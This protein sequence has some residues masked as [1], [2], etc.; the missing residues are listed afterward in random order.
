MR[1]SVKNLFFALLMMFTLTA[2]AWAGT[3]LSGLMGGD[4]TDPE[5]KIQVPST[6]TTA[7]DWPTHYTDATW[8]SIQ[9]YGKGP[10]QTNECPANLFNNLVG[11]GTYKWFDSFGPSATNPA[12]VT[13]QFPEAFVL[14][15]FTLTSGNDSMTSRNP[16]DWCIYGSND[17]VNWTPIYHATSTADFTETTN[18][19]L[20]YSSFTY[21]D[22]NITSDT[23][24]NDAQKAAVSTSLGSGKTVS[25]PDFATPAAYSWY[26]LQV[27]STSGGGATQLGELELF[28][29]KVSTGRTSGNPFLPLTQLMDHVGSVY[30]LDAQKSSSLTVDANNK[31]SAWRDSNS[32]GF[33]F[34]QTTEEF[35]PVLST[36]TINGQEFNALEFTKTARDD[37]H[38]QGGQSLITNQ[39]VNAQTVFI[40]AQN[41]INDSLTGIWGESYD[42]GIRLSSGTGLWQ[43]SPGN[44][45]DFI[46]AQSGTPNGQ[47]YYNGLEK[48]EFTGVL[49]NNLVLTEAAR[50][51][52]RALNTHRIGSYFMWNDYGPGSR[53]YD[54]KILEVVVYDHSLTD[55]ETKAVNTSFA[56]K[57]GIEIA[58]TLDIFPGPINETAYKND[59]IGVINRTIDGKEYFQ[60]CSGEG[61]LGIYGKITGTKAA[62]SAYD[63]FSLTTYQ[64]PSDGTEIYAVA[65]MPAGTAAGILTD[66]EGIK[67]STYDKWEKEWYFTNKSVGAQDW[68]ITL[69][70][71]AEEANFTDFE[72]YADSEWYLIF[73]TD[74]DGQY[75]RVGDLD[76]QKFNEKM[77]SFTF[78]ASLLQTGFYTLGVMTAPE[79]PEPAAWIMILV[80][81]AGIGAVRKRLLRQNP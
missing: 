55:Y 50:D 51:S 61:G 66:I 1:N 74:E 46:N 12:Y 13:L 65:N 56:L 78:P 29:N 21:A 20:L 14:T 34:T 22:G 45:S 58:N 31:V 41:D 43:D 15:H 54:G 48:S 75:F 16:K 77:I 18:T 68:E 27:N 72:S 76:P 33:E 53:G 71:N 23:V 9:S 6:Y 63:I 64:S 44:E 69:E 42:Y 3:Q 17:G 36:I 70:F 35:R 7:D 2:G 73:K 60:D 49:K 47:Y 80:G 59:V 37:D 30:S 26:K 8:L 52:Y 4:V 38:P 57:Y 40:L 24:L 67:G 19:T 79:V 39:R 81:L 10:Y 5:N 11:G 28:G 62:E 32:N 25:T